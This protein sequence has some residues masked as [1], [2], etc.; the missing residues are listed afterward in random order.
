MSIQNFFVSGFGKLYRS[1]GNCDDQFE[2]HVVVDGVL[3]EDGKVLV[4]INSNFGDTA[5]I[6]NTCA[7][8][9]KDIC[10]EFEGND[11]GDEPTKIGSGPSAACIFTD[12]DV[13]AC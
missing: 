5:A 11:N 12:A 8:D 9:V 3:A 13:S 2:R 1:C 7:V 10:Q 6:T 4:G